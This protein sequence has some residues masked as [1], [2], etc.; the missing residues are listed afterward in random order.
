[1]RAP[2]L[3]QPG[4]TRGPFRR[5]GVFP[6]AFRFRTQLCCTERWA[7]FEHLVVPR[8]TFPPPSNQ[9]A[10]V[11]SMSLRGALFGALLAVSTLAVHAQ[12]VQ[13]RTIK[14]GHLNNT[15]HPVSMGVKKFSELLA[16]KSGGK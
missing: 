4:N 15:D 7:G 2:R 11:K 9:G 14:F 16:A 3:R 10:P 8:R 1:M 12:D 5:R 6:H 13:E